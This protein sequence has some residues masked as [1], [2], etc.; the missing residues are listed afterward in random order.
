MAQ[1]VLQSSPTSRLEAWFYETL[2]DGRTLVK[3][4]GILHALLAWEARPGD[5]YSKYGAKEKRGGSC[6]KVEYE[7]GELGHVGMLAERT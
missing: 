5:R 4:L 1:L 6:G 2:L 3:V 7:Y